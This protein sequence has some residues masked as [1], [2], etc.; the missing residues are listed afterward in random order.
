MRYDFL[1]LALLFLLPG[2][3]VFILRRDLRGVIAVMALF[4]LPFAGTE[5]LFYPA[6]WEPVFL[7]DL[8]RTIGFGIEDVIFVIGLAAF[9]ATGYAFV[10]RKRYTPRPKG[11]AGWSF[12]A[13][14]FLLATFALVAIAWAFSIPMIYGSVIIMYLAVAVI[15]ILRRDLILPALLGAV[16]TA[17]T[18]FILCLIFAVLF[19][20]AFTNVWH[21]DMFMNVFLFG[22]PIE[23]VLYGSAAGAIA[24]VFYPFVFRYE[25][26][27]KDARPEGA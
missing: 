3:V 11:R 19:P 14:V 7:F 21:T 10:F 27:N 17:A 6:Y 2:C 15:V 20:A 8:A 26:A 25:F 24:T 12:R 18:Y 16:V 4:A 5:F 9:T 1:I 23:E 13:G 22:V